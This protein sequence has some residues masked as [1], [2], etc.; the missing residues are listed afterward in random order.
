MLGLIGTRLR[1]SSKAVNA[2]GFLT[3]VNAGKSYLFNF[4]EVEPQ[5]LDGLNH[6]QEGDKKTALTKAL[7]ESG[8]E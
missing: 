3:S 7:I 4:E 8:V 6:L 2:Y 5:N 1:I